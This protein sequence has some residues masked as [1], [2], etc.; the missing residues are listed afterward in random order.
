MGYVIPVNLPDL[1]LHELNRLSSKGRW[2]FLNSGNQVYYAGDG[3]DRGLPSSPVV[4]L[5]QGLFDQHRDLSFFL[6]RKRIFTN[7]PLSRMD[8]GF[9][10]VVAKRVTEL[11]T[12]LAS[13][14]AIRTRFEFIQVAEVDSDHF[15]SK[16][17]MP[18]LA[19]GRWNHLRE[20]QILSAL[21]ELESQVIRSGDLHDQYRPIGV[22]LTQSDGVVLGYGRH[23]G[24][25]NKTLH[26]EVEL[27]QRLFREGFRPQPN[28]TYHLWVSLKPCRM[29]AGLIAHV[30][31]KQI[32]VHF[33]DLD[34]G[35]L[36]QG[37]ALEA[38]GIQR[39]IP[40]RS[41]VD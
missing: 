28:Q 16:L 34:P 4:K 40:L 6:L 8:K 21:A 3:G 1:I 5:I 22:V 41:R 23:A 32:Q 11:T 33:R 20:D 12:P 35:R 7:Y 31:G 26:A 14:E 39:Q 30:F 36:A 18:T 17:P 10:D 29:C 25:I 13:P 19:A 24:M 9:I 15:Q 27:V 38:L 37:T 2:A